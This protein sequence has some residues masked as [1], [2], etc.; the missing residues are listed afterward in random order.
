MI[1]LKIDPNVRDD[2][3]N[4]VAFVEPGEP[5]P[6][7]GDTVMLWDD[8]GETR[9]QGIVDHKRPTVDADD[10]GIILSIVPLWGTVEW[11]EA[12]HWVNVDN[13]MHRTTLSPEAYEG[14][15]EALDAPPRYLPG[16]AK[17]LAK[18][19]PFESRLDDPQ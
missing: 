10:Y 9:F 15:L 3:G 2:Y 19:T 17:L 12:G 8:D 11:L 14:F 6:S 18:E 13:N 1:D 16:L 7:C 5:E 4:A